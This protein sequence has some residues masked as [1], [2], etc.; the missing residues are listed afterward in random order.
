MPRTGGMCRGP[1]V[2]R[3][4]VR[5]GRG[6]GGVDLLDPPLL[7]C[8]PFPGLALRPHWGGGHTL[9]PLRV[10]GPLPREDHV[11]FGGSQPRRHCTVLDR[12]DTQKVKRV[13]PPPVSTA[14][15]SGAHV[16]IGALST[17]SLI[18]TPWVPPPP[19]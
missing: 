7:C 4:V 10:C 9:H 15:I 3:R 1:V 8:R 2:R 12:M 11:Y 13:P 19:P 14:K 16:P 6:S 18:P 5:K 17:N